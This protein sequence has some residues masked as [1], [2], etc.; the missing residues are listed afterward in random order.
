VSCHK[1]WLAVDGTAVQRRDQKPFKIYAVMNSFSGDT[2]ETLRVTG[3]ISTG[4]Y[5]IS[6]GFQLCVL[7]P[8]LNSAPV[9]GTVSQLLVVPF[10]T[11][12]I[13]MQTVTGG[14]VY[15]LVDLEPEF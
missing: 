13:S 11:T 4:V 8:P 2:T 10:E 7:P 6:G 3:I 1:T 14:L 15:V 9:S 5:N 12:A